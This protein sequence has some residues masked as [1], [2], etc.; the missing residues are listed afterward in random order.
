MSYYASVIM[1]R[2]YEGFHKGDKI[3]ESPSPALYSQRYL[4]KMYNPHNNPNKA[5]Y[6]NKAA[7]NYGRKPTIED[8]CYQC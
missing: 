2:V 4:N 6:G 7:S 5:D 3:R 1:G 8:R